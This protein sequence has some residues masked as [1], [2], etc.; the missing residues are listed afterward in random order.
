VLAQCEYPVKEVFKSIRE[1]KTAPNS[2]QTPADKFSFITVN[3][4]HSCLDKV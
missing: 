2:V 1:G 3:E 4:F